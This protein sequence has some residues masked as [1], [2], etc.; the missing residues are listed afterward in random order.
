M[1]PSR[2]CC[3]L[4]GAKEPIANLADAVEHLFGCLR[5]EH[6]RPRIAPGHRAE[7]DPGAAGRFEVALSDAWPQ[8]PRDDGVFLADLGSERLSIRSG[9]EATVTPCDTPAGP[10]ERCDPVTA[11]TLEA[12]ILGPAQS[13]VGV[14]KIR[15]RIV[16]A[17]GLLVARTRKSDGASAC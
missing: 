14:V 13:E 17:D 6:I 7:C 10:F 4:V 1:K 16:D 8:A 3:S 15:G 5:L 11:A 12:L 9:D 2:T